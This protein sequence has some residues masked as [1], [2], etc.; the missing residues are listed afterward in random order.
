MVQPQPDSTGSSEV[1]A[2]PPSHLHLRQ[3]ELWDPS[4][5]HW[6]RGT[7]E[8]HNVP[9]T[10]RWDS[11]VC[12]GQLSNEGYSCKLSAAS[13]P[14]TGGRMPQLG[15]GYLDRAPRASPTI[16]FWPTNMTSPR[17]SSHWPP[18]QNQTLC[19]STQSLQLQNQQQLQ[20]EKLEVSSKVTSYVLVNTTIHRQK[21]DLK[22][23][24]CLCL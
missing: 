19:S 24:V 14:S 17:S 6:L 11:P 7:W 21:R 18:V 12:Q 9:G 1:W 23:K 13:P 5:F 22:R 15:K 20:E 10:S 2:T 3:R 16:P 8:W 4:M